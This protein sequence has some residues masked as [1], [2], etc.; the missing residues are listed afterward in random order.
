VLVAGLVAL[1]LA[2]AGLTYALLH[3]ENTGD[4]AGGG[5]SRSGAVLSPSPAP[6]T[7][8][9]TTNPS[10]T[11]G[12]SGNSASRTA[13]AQSVTVTV[14]GARTEYDG[15]CPPPRAQAP[16][17]TATFTVGRLPAHVS[18]RWVAK[19]GAV[20]DGGWRTLSFPAGG[21]RSR[22]ERVAV[23][24]YSGGGT[25]RD[26]VGVEVRDPVRARSNTVPFSVTCASETPTGGASG[27]A[28]ASA[29]P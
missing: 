3:H 23:T 5:S 6:R 27:S 8:P 1:A 26:A 15:A 19:G 4:A 29:S 22:Q 16:S 7:A 18:Y 17:F 12:T 21:G 11:S 28:S 9:R 24:T 10:P 2:L 14:A 25:L 20:A 13:S